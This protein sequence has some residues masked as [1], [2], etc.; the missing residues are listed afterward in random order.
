[1]GSGNITLL[2]NTSTILKK[3][4]PNVKKAVVFQEWIIVRLLFPC[5]LSLYYDFIS[6]L[7]SAISP[8]FLVEKMKKQDAKRKE[9]NL[10]FWS[11]SCGCTGDFLTSPCF[12]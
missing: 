11:L 12:I 7:K 3:L 1:M 5:Q 10:Q 2:L 4:L 6:D 8:Q 9:H